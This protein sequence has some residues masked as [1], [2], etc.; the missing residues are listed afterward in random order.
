[1]PSFGATIFT[2]PTTP[3]HPLNTRTTLTT[4]IFIDLREDPPKILFVVI[5]KQQWCHAKQTPKGDPQRTRCQTYLSKQTY[6]EDQWWVLY[7]NGEDQWW[8]L[9]TNGEDQWWVL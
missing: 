3:L 6:G 4:I 8:V 5:D 9:Y 2:T 1:M 7:T